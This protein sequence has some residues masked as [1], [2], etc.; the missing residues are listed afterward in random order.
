MSKGALQVV[1]NDGRCFVWFDHCDLEVR[2]RRRTVL[3]KL[4]AGAASNEPGAEIVILAEL[5]SSPPKAR[6]RRP[7]PAP[8]MQ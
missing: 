5:A 6:V 7:K 2:D 4:N 8:A 1:E 3:F